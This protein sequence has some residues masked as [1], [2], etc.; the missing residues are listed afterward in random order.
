MARSHAKIL[1]TV[2][3][4]PDWCAL[5]PREQ[6][7]YML[8]LSQP[9]LSLV[10]SLDYLPGRWSAF[11]EGLTVDYIDLC[12]NGLEDAG[13]VCVDRTTDEVLIRSFTR[14]DGIPTSN[15]RLR[16][17]L[18]G[19]YGQVASSLL[20][21]VA[22]DNMPDELFAFPVPPE[23]ER[24]RR[25]EPIEWAMQHPIGRVSEPPVPCSLP[26][27]TYHQPPTT[28]TQSNTRPGRTVDDHRPRLTPVAEVLNSR[29]P[30][31]PEL[32]IA[33][34]HNLRATLHPTM[35]EPA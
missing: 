20:R 21:K 3:H 16:K 29:P 2:W 34:L 10:G 23:A 30:I 31:D 35:G 22:V 25:S 8:L 26:P 6:W 9:K 11:G 5:K 28:G 33:S 19:A 24:F 13:Y 15:E 1:A 7:A 4:D 17:G 27:A 12:I 18:W 32:N 14:G